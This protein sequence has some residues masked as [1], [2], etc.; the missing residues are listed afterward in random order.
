MLSRNLKY[1]R[2]QRKLTQ[3]QLAEMIGVSRPTLGD[4]ENGNSD[5]PAAVLKRL[6]EVFQKSLDDL[7]F[8]DLGAPLFQRGGK[9]EKTLSGNEV[10]ILAVTL[11]DDERENIEFIP[12]Q[13]FAGYATSYADPEFVSGLQRFHLPKH[14]HGTYR[15]FEI[16]GDSMP[17]VDDG[18][19]VIGRYMEDWR[20]LASGKRHVLILREQGVVFKRI[21]KE[22]HFGKLT[23]ISDNP[24]Y[25]PFSV[26]STEICEAWEMVSYIAFPKEATSYDNLIFDKLQAIEQ[27]IDALAFLKPRKGN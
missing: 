25:K 10:R 9:E 11:R 2:R 5:P 7:V 26:K 14:E 12:V 4:Y 19:I 20:D 3:A 24:A 1:L 15:A 22:G 27:K 8:S 6:A 16:K 21:I 13:A 18:Y 17:P 23:L